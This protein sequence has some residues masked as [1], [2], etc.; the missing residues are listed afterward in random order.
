MSKRPREDK[1]ISA[2]KDIL[3]DISNEMAESLLEKTNN[4]V[5]NA[6]NLY[7]TSPPQATTSSRRDPI[8]TT[9]DQIYIGELVITGWSL[10]K[11]RSPVKEG[12][13]I[14]IVRDNLSSAK[15]KI[16]RFCLK[17]TKPGTNTVELREIG[18][19]SKEVA[20][21][22]AVLMDQKL[23]TFEGS[24]VWCP[25]ILATGDDVILSIRC[26]LLHEVFK[27][28]VFTSTR[29]SISK[30]RK[31][32]NNR[33]SNTTLDL[34]DLRKIALIKL[35]KALCMT[36]SRSAIQGREDNNVF[37]KILTS[38][39]NKDDKESG[40]EVNGD[41]ETSVEEDKAVSDDQLDT[42][43]EK[44]QLF[45]AEM[46]PAEQP[47]TLS[48]ELKEYQKRALAW[49]MKKEAFE[50]EDDD[51]AM[52]AL[53][54]LWEEYMFPN[55]YQQQ[56]YFYF[57]PFSGEL[58]LSFPEANSRER[59]GILADAQWRDEITKAS[60]PGTINVDIYYGNERI[61]DI[62]R[63][64]CRWDGS[65]PDIL[66]TTYGVI[67]SEWVNME[68]KDDK[69]QLFKIDFWRVVLDEAHQ[70]KNRLSKTSQACRDIK[71]RRRW[72]VTGTPIQNKL[73]DLYSL[74]RFL[75]HEPWA[76][77]TFWRTF[78][79]LPFEKKDPSA[80][81]AVQNVLEPIVLRRT[82]SMRDKLGQLMV[83]LPAKIINIEY[84]LFTPEEQ[85]IY[86]AIYNDSNTKFSYFCQAGTLGHNYASIFQLLIRLR[87]I[88]CH[89]YLVLKGH[90]DDRVESESGHGIK[91]EDLIKKRLGG[92]DDMADN[93]TLN[94]NNRNFELNVLQDMLAL[95]QRSSPDHH[96]DTDIKEDIS[97]FPSECP[98][99]FEGVETIIAMPCMHMACRPCIMDYFQK[100]EE[101][102]L[103]GEC[104]ICRH[105][106]IE[107][108]Q[109]LEIVLQQKKEDVLDTD[110]LK[111]D[112]RKAIGG[113]KP[114]SKMQALL[115]HLR[116]NIAGDHKTVVFSQFTTYLDLI[117]EALDR[118][119]MSFT[120]L[121]GSQ[122]QSQREKV[123]SAFSKSDGS[124]ANV[125]LIS[126]RAG[127][128]GLNLTCAD[129]IILMDPWWNFAVESQAIDR[130]HRLGQ[131]NDVV[132]TRFIM[133]DTVEER[134]LE[135]QN[136][137]HQ[138]ANDLYLSRSEVKSQRLDDLRLLFRKN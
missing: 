58:S 136:R 91:L 30:K 50:H 109:L 13:T 1:W 69:K 64:L 71:A 70:I 63:K 123:L 133:R 78:I 52:R 106:P 46:T 122:S 83:P 57:N 60:K 31:T 26:Y 118:E 28:D 12:D 95:Q 84:L 115:R 15:N 54:P 5:E 112:V 39:S 117:G 62:Q 38:V 97:S 19:L 94:S 49:M 130:V 9:P 111:F 134:M 16:V 37:D 68:Q 20:E 35:F 56:K 11:G 42:I 75:R 131:S 59:G 44:A 98:I 85:D 103:P 135:I 88:C 48:I 32:V 80:I 119:H 77:L 53:H 51:L 90:K 125:L 22:M 114:S 45:D 61:D 25:D 89:P 127:G 40:E 116:K 86:D 8:T 137:K 96:I 65:A 23:C 120:R 27:S 4:N 107:G 67:M 79:T 132:V 100:K 21:Y 113:F 104:P 129:R 10:Y 110:N 7:F 73:E 17:S 93:D 24:L 138:L 102:G 2:L 6:I 36:P 105:G 34:L 99:C 87:Q 41:G 124:G 82:K 92:S 43:Y 108:S 47:E 14:A 33:S 74:V 72:A 29:T 126:L 66:I 76:N 3:G 81:S 128:V 18:R 101:E 121:D 55:E